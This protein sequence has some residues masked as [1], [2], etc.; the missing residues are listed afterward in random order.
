MRHRISLSAA[1][2]L[3]LLAGTYGAAAQ[4]DFFESI[5]ALTD[6]TE[7]GAQ[8]QALMQQGIRFSLVYTNAALGN[9]SGGIRRLAI[10]EGKLEA[11]VGLDLEKLAGLEGWS[12]YV[13]MFQLHHT[14]GMQQDNFD[15]GVTISNIEALP[16]TRL[17]E[18]YLE[19]KFSDERFSIRFGQI[20][21]DSE[22]FISD[23]SIPFV[24]SDWPAITTA[25]LPSGGPAYPLA[26]PGV[27]FRYD[28][29]PQWSALIAVFNGD[30]GE[31]GTVN[32][33]GTNFPL[34]DPPLMLAELQHRYNQEKEARGLAGI[35]RVGGW[36]YFG[37]VDD[38][39]FDTL[40]L[41][42]AN[43][44]SNGIPRQWRGTSG[45]YGIVDQQI[46]RPK[47]GGPNSG[48][49][50]FSRIAA[51]PSD[52]STIGFYLDGGI[53]FSGFVEHRPKD[54][55]GAT[56]IF[57]KY[58]DKVGALD[59]DAIFYSG[60]KRPV[61]DYEM[62]LELNYTALIRAGWA[63]QPYFQYLVHPG[64]SVPNSNDPTQPIRN[65]AMIGLRST[66]A[67]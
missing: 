61:H 56:F 43:P 4:A 35:L 65:G 44:L 62:I 30:P 3:M 13:N 66:L 14:R 16:A 21:A 45:V 27:R 39:R 10:Y 37:K 15:G 12:L 67:Y 18:Y 60:M 25:N 23:Y 22:F 38:R 17:Q 7:R 50:L 26:T 34:N 64:G 24:T 6:R 52:R 46:Y 8:R 19:R 31:Q 47:S 1:T 2:F 55:F 36:H 57:A 9:L 20:A 59:R 49:A 11:S 51:S 32:R 42:L 53:L 54:K 33:T 41:S 40:G 48:I 5:G 29:N 28:P 63:L 58:A